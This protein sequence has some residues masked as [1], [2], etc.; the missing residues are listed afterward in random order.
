MGKRKKQIRRPAPT[1]KVSF[2]ENCE[3]F[4]SHLVAA[5]KDDLQRA[6][7]LARSRGH[8]FQVDAYKRVLWVRLNAVIKSVIRGF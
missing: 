2:E 5:S 8:D 4:M 7:Q 6:S 3:R 1:D